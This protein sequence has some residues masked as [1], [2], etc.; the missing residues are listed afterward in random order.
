MKVV[1][2]NLESVEPQAET[3]RVD[4][5]TKRGARAYVTTYLLSSPSRIMPVVVIGHGRVEGK[6]GLKALLCESKEIPPATS[7]WSA[8]QRCILRST[9]ESLLMWVLGPTRDRGEAGALDPTA[10]TGL[11]FR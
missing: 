5:V 2:D 11:I 4:L 3:R 10:V 8:P 1:V 6:V 7:A 9:D